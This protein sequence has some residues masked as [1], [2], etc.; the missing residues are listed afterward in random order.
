MNP[1]REFELLAELAKLLKKYGAAPFE[2]LAQQLSNQ[3]FLDRVTLV[4]SAAAEAAK[5]PRMKASP[6]PRKT[7]MAEWHGH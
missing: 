7:G 1:G 4:L 5:S 3:E 2:Q 6:A